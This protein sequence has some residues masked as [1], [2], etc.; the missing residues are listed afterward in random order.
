MMIIMILSEGYRVLGSIQ[1]VAPAE[2][3]P[4]QPVCGRVYPRALQA[5]IDDRRTCIAHHYS[6]E[7]SPSKQTTHRVHSHLSRHHEYQLMD[8]D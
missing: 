5:D 8:S 6:L 4:I 2:T 3:G 7:G 1:I